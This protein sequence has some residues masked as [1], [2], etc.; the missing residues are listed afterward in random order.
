VS[1][2]PQDPVTP[3]IG[4][5]PYS[6]QDAPFF[7]GRERERAMITAN[8]MASRL[9]VLYGPSGAGKSSVLRAG[10]EHTLREQARRNFEEHGEP[11]LAVI[12]FNN[13]RDDPL[14]GLSLTIHAVVKQTLAAMG[15]VDDSVSVPQEFVEN[16]ETWTKRIDGEL[17]IILDQFEEYFMY[18]AQEDGEHTFAVEFPRAVNRVGLRVNFLVSLREDALSK[19]DRFKGRIPNLFDNYLRIGHLTQEAARDAIEKPVEE[20][21]RRQTIAAD[22]VTI[23]PALV[24][25]VLSQVQT[26]RVT[27]ARGGSG[28][29]ADGNPRAEATIETSYLQLVMTRL[30]HEEMQAGSHI[31]RLT[32]LERLKGAEQIVRTHLDSVMDQLSSEESAMAADVFRYLV[33]PSGTKIAYTRTD[34]AAYTNTPGAQLTPVLEKLSG[35]GLRILRTVDPP[36]D[37]PRETRYEIFHDVLAAAI[38]DWRGR[39]MLEK[40]KRE[41]E[42]RLAEE[43]RAEQQRL[44]EERRQKEL[45]DARKLAESEAKASRRLRRLTAALVVV[46]IF[47]IIAAGLALRNSIDADAQRKVAEQKSVEADQQ[48]QAADAQ[49]AVA[50]EKSVEAD[51][52]RQVAEAN[53]ETARMYQADYQVTLLN[54]LNDI[55]TSKGLPPLV[56]ND[57]LSRVAQAHSKS[58][59]ENNYL[60]EQRITQAGYGAG[61]PAEAIFASFIDSTL[62]DALNW[63]EN[64]PVHLARL[65]DPI[66]TVVGIG[67][68]KSDSATYGSYYTYDFG[69]P[70]P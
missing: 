32:T 51:Q 49:R 58:M 18:H 1:N 14:V 39:Y 41:F 37:Q 4:L 31:L 28:S 34:L 21:N 67:I 19:L 24:E 30:W 38:L 27:L 60:G 20:F 65:L 8:L 56:L 59:A 69:K 6:E 16:L 57:D 7:F 64:S 50:E 55:R 63:W 40:D 42:Q 43:A 33:T 29:V 5:I 2:L 22:R 23:E 70:A 15:Q 54:R 36:P 68:Y 3:Y 26:G 45:D 35:S 48:R 66:N 10:V 12:V 11:E 46:S 9:T 62:D 53:A 44:E 13:W 47:A 61:H 52:Q 17:L 25:A